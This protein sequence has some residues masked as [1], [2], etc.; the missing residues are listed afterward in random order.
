MI[1]FTGNNMKRINIGRSMLE[2]VGVLAIIGMLSLLSLFGFR[3]AMTYHKANETIHDVMLRATNVPM[4][5]DDY[6]N[7]AQEEFIFTDLGAYNERNPVGF[8]V[9]TY[10]EPAE[11]VYAYRVEVLSLTQE[12]CRRI[13]NMNPTDIDLIKVG[14]EAVAGGE[15]E[16]ATALDCDT[17]TINMA[18]YFEGVAANKCDP[19][20]E[21]DECCIDGECGECP[22]PPV[23]VVCD[24]P[25]NEE[26]QVCENGKCRNRANNLSCGDSGCCQDGACGTC[27]EPPVPGCTKNT[28]C[29][30]GLCCKNGTCQNCDPDCPLTRC[31]ECQKETGA[32]AKGCPIC[33]TD[34]TDD[35]CGLK[36]AAKECCENNTLNCGPCE[37][38]NY[39][40][41]Q[42]VPTYDAKP[43]ACH[44][45]DEDNCGWISPCPENSKCNE[46]SSLCECNSGYEFSTDNK[47]CC[48]IQPEPENPGCYE[49]KDQDNDGCLE[50]VFKCTEGEE[51]TNN[52]CT[53][54]PCPNGC[55][56]TGGNENTYTCSEHSKC[57]SKY[58]GDMANNATQNNLPYYLHKGQKIQADL[59]GCPD[60]QVPYV[61][62]QTDSYWTTQNGCCPEGYSAQQ[63][64]G[65]TSLYEICC[66]EGFTA[67][68]GSGQ[69]GECCPDENLQQINGV[70]T[71]DPCRVLTQTVTCK[72]DRT[73][74][75][76]A[77]CAES[78]N[79]PND[80]TEYVVSTQPR[81]CCDEGKEPTELEQIE[82]D[83]IDC[84]HEHITYQCCT[85]GKKKQIL[86]ETYELEGWFEVCAD[87][88]NWIDS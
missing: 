16:N 41:C 29:A 44:V 32:D 79:Y 5:W 19:V 6:E 8:E 50:Y 48:V 63:P 13:I 74:G 10:P 73:T 15:G 88:P 18:F 51:C 34:E 62:A 71:C 86:P 23:P 37:E 1:F 25:C 30:S 64:K 12:I 14:D 47:K 87:D 49:K 38:P 4:K 2:M 36:G 69:G 76:M 21:E 53:F 65:A 31:A 70:W 59:V 84:V 46:E 22:E 78:S 66:Q 26:C 11:S 77:C 60:N 35:C 56:I 61:I 43:S 67:Y 80:A 28:Q 57:Y 39:E 68:T 40:T 82:I 7:F 83:P 3:L 54:N 17:E 55:L 72:G 45:F 33:E 42:C 58:L 85:D 52:Q 27:T 24:P 9:H 81:L 20:C 75:D